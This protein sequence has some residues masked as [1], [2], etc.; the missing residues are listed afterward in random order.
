M[1]KNRPLTNTKSSKAQIAIQPPIMIT[2]GA[3]M[4]KRT[5]N[6]NAI[7]RISKSSAPRF[8]W[9][10]TEFFRIDKFMKTFRDFLNEK[11]NTLDTLHDPG[12]RSYYSRHRV[13]PDNRKEFEFLREIPLIALQAGPAARRDLQTFLQR[14]ATVVPEVAPLVKK[15][16][17]LTA[18]DARDAKKLIDPSDVQH[19]LSGHEEDELDGDQL[20][21]ENPLDDEEI[22]PNEDEEEFM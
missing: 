14:I 20:G 13:T 1:R 2:K 18:Q 8:N 19:D 21:G 12:I 4:T 10:K 3:A 15:I 5:T 7:D 16:G 11:V 17:I 6:V 22:R 9:F